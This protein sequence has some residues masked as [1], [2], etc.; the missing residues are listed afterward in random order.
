MWRT[1]FRQWAQNVA[2]EAMERQMRGSNAPSEESSDHR[3]DA[4][5]ICA[6]ALESGGLEDRLENTL[7]LKTA[8]G[9][10]C[11]GQAGP[12]RV[13][14][15]TA[16]PGG[17]AAAR[18]AEAVLVAHRPRLLISAG[19][20]GALHD[21]LR[22][23]HVLFPTEVINTAGRVLQ[24]PRLV[25]DAETPP[26]VHL[27]RLLSADQ[28]VSSPAE[29]QRLADTFQAL[30]ADLETFAV[31]S[32]CRQQGVP[33]AAVRVI[34][35]TVDEILPPE[36]AFLMRPRKWTEKMGA[37]VGAVWNRPS[38]VKDLWR[39]QEVALQAGDILATQILALV[40]TL[41]PDQS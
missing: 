23:L 11:L 4:V 25:A 39:L 6:L 38:S 2:A 13:A 28:I 32:V 5:V 9:R 22:R 31:A 30:A 16:G 10:V 8:V 17:D 33:L 37:V 26:G 1:I 20:A 36:V 27:G 24:L 7:C 19:F 18:A 14:V 12:V 41:K 40:Q 3:V 15:V 21:G 34:T 35:D 29:K